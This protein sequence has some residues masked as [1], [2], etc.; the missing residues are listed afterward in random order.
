L[1]KRERESRAL[2]LQNIKD[3]DAKSWEKELRCGVKL[4]TKAQR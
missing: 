4:T 1:G 2:G 3:N